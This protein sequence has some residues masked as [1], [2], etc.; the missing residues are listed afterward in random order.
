[1]LSFEYASKHPWLAGA[2]T[3]ESATAD[4]DTWRLDRRLLQMAVKWRWKKE[5]GLPDWETDS[6]MFARYANALRG[7]DGGSKTLR[8]GQSGAAPEPYANLWVA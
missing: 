8:F 7:R 4:T 5:K 1:M 3:Q 6:Q 2:V